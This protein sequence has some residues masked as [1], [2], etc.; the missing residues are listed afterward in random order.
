MGKVQIHFK[1]GGIKTTSQM[2]VAWE[3]NMRLDKCENVDHDLSHLNEVI[4]DRGMSYSKYYKERMA[5]DY[6]PRIHPV[7]GSP[8]AIKSDAVKIMDVMISVNGNETK[9]NPLFDI[10]EFKKR[11]KEFAIEKFGEKNIAGMVYHADEGAPHI[12]IEVIPLTPEGRLNSHYYNTPKLLASYQT[13]LANKMKDLGLNRG[14]ERAVT[15]RRD[16]KDYMGDIKAART[17]TLP[18][19]ETGENIHNFKLRCD[20]ELKK[21]QSQNMHEK[22][23]LQSKIR[24]LETTLRQ[25]GRGREEE[26][27]K[28]NKDLKN[29]L[30]AANKTINELKSDV[31]D[32]ENSMLQ[33]GDVARA[34]QH[35]LMDKDDEKDLIDLTKLAVQYGREYREEREN[36]DK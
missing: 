7:S 1:P 9:T 28:E 24:D 4:I 31:A 19:P 23:Q 3:H 22:D 25:S 30:D 29:D 13:D 10:D 20:A 12:H 11:C 15:D 6:V 2:T 35:H 34:I 32:L 17:S 8:I 14:R 16:I 5:S 33:W 36:K 21:I 27:L 18:E 26:L